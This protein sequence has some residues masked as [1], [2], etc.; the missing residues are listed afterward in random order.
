MLSLMEW[1]IT[2]R[3]VRKILTDVIDSLENTVTSSEHIIIYLLGSNKCR[4]GK[5]QRREQ[6]TI[7]IVEIEI[8]T[9]TLTVFPTFLV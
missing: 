9:G 1:D 5:S 8:E 2:F 4:R 7:K 3:M 6:V